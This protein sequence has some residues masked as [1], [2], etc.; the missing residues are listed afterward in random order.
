MCVCAQ[1]LSHVRLFAVLWTVAC[2]VPLSMEFSRQEYWNGLPF[3]FPG[4]LPHP[5]IK[6]A[7]P[8]LQEDSLSTE[9]QGSPILNSER[10]PVLKE[11]RQNINIHSSL[12]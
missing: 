9:P 4:A 10:K 3:R 2:P 12:F 6:P 1:P 11:I 5:G 8:A 7:S